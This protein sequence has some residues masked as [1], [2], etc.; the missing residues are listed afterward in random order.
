[1]RCS[2][3]IEYI[4]RQKYGYGDIRNIYNLADSQVR[5][6]AGYT[7]R[8]LARQSMIVGQIFD[9]VDERITRG[10]S[11][12]LALV[13]VTIAVHGNSRRHV[14]PPV[15]TRS[16]G[17]ARAAERRIILL[18]SRRLSLENIEHGDERCRCLDRRSTAFAVALSKVRISCGKQAAA[19]RNRQVQ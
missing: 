9:H 3:A 10:Q 14:V 5:G 12:V 6:H 17:V 11:Q 4:E 15:D 13:T 2:G 7:V 18:A 16:A 19:H 1:M 8:L